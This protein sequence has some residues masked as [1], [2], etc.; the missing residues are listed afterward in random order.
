MP[1]GNINTVTFKIHLYAQWLSEYGYNRDTYTTPSD[2][3][4]TVSRNINSHAQWLSHH[5]SPVAI[6][7]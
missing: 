7:M 6:S 2:N 1:S 3:I 5:I 4:N